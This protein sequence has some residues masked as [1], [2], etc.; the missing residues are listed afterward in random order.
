MGNARSFP[1]TRSEEGAADFPLL[2]PSRFSPETNTAALLSELISEIKGLR[3][4]I[5]MRDLRDGKMPMSIQFLLN[6]GNSDD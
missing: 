5:K 1:R 3:N 6:E 2:A 4:D